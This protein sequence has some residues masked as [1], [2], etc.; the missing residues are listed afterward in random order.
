M[1]F[2]D[3]KVSHLDAVALLGV[4]CALACWGFNG[5]REIGL[6]QASGHLICTLGD[7]EAQIFG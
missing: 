7:V 6:A 2:V 3:D 4:R 1:T 5:V